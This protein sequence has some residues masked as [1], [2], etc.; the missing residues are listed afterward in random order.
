[1]RA[2]I[3]LAWRGWG[4]VHPQSRWSGRSV[5]AGGEAGRG[6]VARRIRRAAR[7]GGGAG[8]GRATGPR[9][10]AG[11]DARA[12]RPPG[13]TTALH[14]RH[15][16]QRAFAGSSRRSPIPTRSRAA[17]PI[18][19]GPRAIEVKSACSSRGRG[20]ERRLP[21][22]VPGT[23][24]GPSSRSS[25]P[26]LSMPASPMRP[27]AHAGS[28]GQAAQEYVHWLRAGFDAIGVGGRTARVDDPRSPSA[29]TSARG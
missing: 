11:R 12:L 15:H 25:S 26:P 22:S 1:M 6:R 8:A 21:P 18:A 10:H 5:S 13:K 7:R 19:C 4:R 24:A 2:A 3:Q 29:A 28:R 9:R 20:P 27:A 16:P 23:P 17:E 14:R